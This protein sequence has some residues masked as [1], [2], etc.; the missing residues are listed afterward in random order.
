MCGKFH[1]FKRFFSKFKI[2]I[3]SVLIFIIFPVILSII[4]KKYYFRTPPLDAGDVL[5]Y[6]ATTFGIFGSF[7]TF[8]LTIKKEKE[9]H[10]SKIKPKILVD[11]K[12]ENENIFILTVYNFTENPLKNFFLYDEILCPFMAKELTVYVTYNMSNKEFNKYKEKYK[13]CQFF[14]ITVDEDII[15]NGYPKYILIDCDDVDGRM[16]HCEFNKIEN[17]SQIAYM[18][19]N[20]YLV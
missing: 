2:V 9:S 14:N 12:K 11:L 8:Y 20:V 6:F 7:V 19:S 15:E 4:Y 3:L 1:K 17:G 5:S 16:W 10:N 13:D 18:N